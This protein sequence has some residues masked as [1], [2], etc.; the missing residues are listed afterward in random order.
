MLRQVLMKLKEESAMRQIKVITYGPCTAEVAQENWLSTA[1]LC[2]TNGP[3]TF[4]N[5]SEE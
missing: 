4:T 3:V 5:I 1:E 2:C